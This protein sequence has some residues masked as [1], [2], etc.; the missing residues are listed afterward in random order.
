VSLQHGLLQTWPNPLCPHGDMRARPY[1][2]GRIV[3]G[4][5][6]TLRETKT[7]G[8]RNLGHPG[9]EAFDGLCLGSSEQ[10]EHLSHHMGVVLGPGLRG[11]PTGPSICGTLMWESSSEGGIVAKPPEL[12][13]LKCMSRTLKASTHLNRNNPLVLRISSDRATY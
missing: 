2:M 11:L 12:F 8:L 9:P 13:Q 4:P 10:R 5:L 6:F 3:H 7:W 1:K